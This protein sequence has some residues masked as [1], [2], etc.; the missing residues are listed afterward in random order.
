MSEALETYMRYHISQV[1]D[2]DVDTAKLWA[3]GQDQWCMKHHGMSSVDYYNKLDAKR[4]D[5]MI[6]EWRKQENEDD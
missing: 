3:E 4:N 2:L 6:N 1:R 5:K